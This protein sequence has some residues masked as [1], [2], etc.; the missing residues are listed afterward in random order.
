MEQT[1]DNSQ[2]FAGYWV[3]AQPAVTALVASSINNRHDVEDVLQEVAVSAAKDFSRYDQE[4]PFLPWVLTITRHRVTD[5]FRKRKRS[6]I[7]LDE[8]MLE[9]LSQ[10]TSR[11]ADRISD[12]EVA[13]VECMDRL[14]DRGR[15][16]LE[17]RYHF[18]MTAQAIARKLD[19]STSGVYS[20]LHRL[21][22]ALSFCVEERI[23]G[24]EGK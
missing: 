5:Y 16:I 22:L 4:R 18:D 20:T 6:A 1:K 19:A 3:K 7:S 2:V 24:L 9:L 13:L 15:R 14:P 21:R 17:M 23:K 12:R 11:I 8:D 10:A